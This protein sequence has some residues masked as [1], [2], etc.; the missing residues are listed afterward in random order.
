[1]GNVFATDFDGLSLPTL[2]YDLGPELRWLAPVWNLP[3][4]AGY[5]LNL[6]PVE[7]ESRGRFFVTLSFRF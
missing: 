7:G 2:R 5:G 1:M 4:R 6:D 3:V